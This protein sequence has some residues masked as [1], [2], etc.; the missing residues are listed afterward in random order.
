MFAALNIRGVRLTH[1]KRTNGI[2]D[3]VPDVAEDIP[4]DIRR[5]LLR[6]LRVR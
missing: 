2:Q 1:P 5:I 6:G 3:R 4:V